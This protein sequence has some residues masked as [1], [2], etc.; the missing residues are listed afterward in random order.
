MSMGDGGDVPYIFGDVSLEGGKK[1]LDEYVAF[2]QPTC[3]IVDR[4]LALFAQSH[5]SDLWSQ[6][7]SDI[8]SSGHRLFVIGAE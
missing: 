6:M 7:I 4:P 5:Y 2:D 3:I 1:L 8:D